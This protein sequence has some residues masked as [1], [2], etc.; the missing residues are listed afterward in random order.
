MEERLSGRSTKEAGR[1]EEKE[2]EKSEERRIRKEIAQEVVGGIKEKALLH[3]DAQSQLRKEKP[4]RVSGTVGTARKSRTKKR[5]KW[6]TVKGRTRW[7]CNGLRMRSW[8]RSRERRRM[9]GSSLQ[10]EVMQK[11][12]ELVVHERMSQGKGVKCTEEK[13]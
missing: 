8:R 2:K 9:E 11:V 10:A 4:G 7:K 12:P 13:K 5:M 3:L 1:E 6:K